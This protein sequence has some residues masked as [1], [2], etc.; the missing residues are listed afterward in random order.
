MEE[1]GDVRAE[2]AKQA[3]AHARELRDK[4]DAVTELE[5]LRQAMADPERRAALVKLDLP[6]S[7]LRMGTFCA[8]PLSADVIAAMTRNDDAPPGC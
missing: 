1:I 4:E 3:E 6:R 2:M 7:S 8:E 5:S